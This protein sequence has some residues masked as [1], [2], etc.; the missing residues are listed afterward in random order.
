MSV[1]TTAPAAPGRP[2]AGKRA[3]LILLL[4]GIS[5]ALALL[6]AEV[7]L[8]LVPIAGI[9]YHAFYYDPVTGGKNYP[10]ATLIWRS[11]R[12]D[13]VRRRTNAWGFPDVEHELARAPGTLRIGFFGD[14]Y[15]E[16]MQVPLE[17]TFFR[18]VDRALNA[19]IDELGNMSR[20][21]GEPIRRVEAI[22]FGMSGR[23]T[24]Q[25]YLECG[26]WMERTDLDYVVY[27]FVENDPFDQVRALK[28]SDI[29]PYPVLSADSFTVDRSFHA[30]YGYKDQWPHRVAQYLKAHSLVVS[31][32]EGRLKLLMNYG[33]KRRVTEAER[34]GAVG[35]GGKPGMAPSTWPDSLLGVGWELTERVLDRW[36]RD[37]EGSGRHFVVIRVPREEVLL[38]PLAGQDS[39]APRL[40]EYCARARV[41]LIDPTP[42]L[43]ERFHAGHEIY[44]DHF[45]AEGHRAFAEAFVS[46][47][48]AAECTHH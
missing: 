31:T 37:V 22:C 30:R 16:A 6:S 18:V 41:P 48:V 8:R 36:A 29:V 24:L 5:G 2:S 15:T 44:Y 17:D 12:G 43:A 20:H 47:M 26:Q 11:A 42:H 39:W 27:V 4:A 40:H 21:R 34:T 33:I 10:K 45:T 25:S 35:V 14:S 7:I 32:I 23:G 1:H 13:E 28:E 38:E 9:S 3:A 46:F 19:R